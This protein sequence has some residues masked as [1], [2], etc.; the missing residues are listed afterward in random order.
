[1]NID[2]I[3]K[4][5][6]GSTSE[7]NTATGS[8]KAE[9]KYIKWLFSERKKE[10]ARYYATDISE[11]MEDK[12]FINEILDLYLK[13]YR[14]YDFAE[15]CVT[16]DTEICLKYN[17][18]YKISDRTIV[19]YEN[20]LYALIEEPEQVTRDLYSAHA[21]RLGDDIDMRR[22]VPVYNLAWEIDDE[23]DNPPYIL[24]DILYVQNLHEDY[25]I[26]KGSY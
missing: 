2:T 26:W 18:H 21:F 9:A 1:M 25:N 11:I 13:K 14:I 4:N 5:F 23:D 12:D 24:E 19:E 15:L 7:E 6:I 17:K 16:K 8:Y 10:D 22:L 3:I 20:D